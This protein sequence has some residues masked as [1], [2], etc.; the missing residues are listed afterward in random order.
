[1]CNAVT[2]PI[3]PYRAIVLV[4]REISRA[5]VGRVS[6][7]RRIGSQAPLWRTGSPV[8]ALQVAGPFLAL[9]VAAVAY[10]KLGPADTGS[11]PAVAAWVFG[12]F[13]AILLVAAAIGYAA[14]RSMSAKVRAFAAAEGLD[15]A[16]RNRELTDGWRIAPNCDGAL[17]RDV[18]TGTLGARPLTSFLHQS[19]MDSGRS[20]AMAGL[21]GRHFLGVRVTV[22]DVG[23]PLP[24]VEL[25]PRRL[26]QVENRTLPTGDPV[27]IG[28]PEVE[29][30]YHTRTDDPAFAAELLAPPVVAAL[31][32]APQVA[33]R[34]HGTRLVALASPLAGA[35]G[36]DA[37]VRVLTAVGARLDES[38]GLPSTPGEV[39]GTGPTYV[40]PAVGRWQLTPFG[41]PLGGDA[42]MKDV[43]RGLLGDR[44]YLTFVHERVIGDE[45]DRQVQ[46][47]Q[48]IAVALPARLPR[49]EVWP[50]NTL[51]RI[52]PSLAA[53]E[54][55][56]IESDEF[57]DRFQVAAAD[58]K[59]AVDVLNPRAVAALL[60]VEDF[61][62]R[63][64]GSD[65]VGLWNADTATPGAIHARLAALH[66]VAELIPAHVVADHGWAAEP[67]DVD[68]TTADVDHTLAP[69]RALHVVLAVVVGLHVVGA[70]VPIALAVTGDQP[71]AWLG[72][73]IVVG[74]ITAV[75]V[76]LTIVFGR[77]VD[78]VRRQ[79]KA[80]QPPASSG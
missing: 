12:C 40:P 71:G 4:L 62:W 25:T 35:R 43:R 38:A 45:A 75:A 42:A 54:D 57:N 41:Q 39:R 7:D 56:D 68:T 72:G 49:L 50:E 11:G 48:V 47:E 31:R 37:S 27:A 60:A 21:A 53:R 8:L 5:K 32:Q 10:A 52:A 9:F 63:V 69:V 26:T 13:T 78:S 19:S 18:V 76:T 67:A 55:I 17:S 80:N 23:R 66:T 51:R 61:E 15:F 36:L 28:V 70:G 79:H 30:A 29:A 24:A 58:R 3:V 59:Y 65:L 73:I 20:R 77:V 46:R 6:E 1:M 44:P 22:V 64:D 14:L 16:V 2:G 34:P 74:V 33:V